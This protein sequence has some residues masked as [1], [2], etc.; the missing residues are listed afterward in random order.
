MH[1][2]SGMNTKLETT[3]AEIVATIN[4]DGNSIPIEAE[5]VSRLPRWDAAFVAA[6][7]QSMVI[8]PRWNATRAA[9]LDVGL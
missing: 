6:Q 3:I 1:V 4:N 7:V 5:R 9:F 8:G 2:V